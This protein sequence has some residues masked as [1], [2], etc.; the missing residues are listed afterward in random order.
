MPFPLTWSKLTR[1][2]AP[3]FGRRAE[4][5]G[6]QYLRSLGFLLLASPYRVVTGEIDIV[7]LDGDCLVFVEVKARR[8]DP[9]P[10]DA[11]NL[12]KRRR[13]ERAARHYRRRYPRRDLRYRFD[14]LAVVQPAGG[15]PEFRLIK[16]AFRESE[17]L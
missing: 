15:E 7:A 13:I 1:T 17:D 11:V 14:I 3:S 2:K 4:I 12:E 5:L 10:E 9:H 6:A 8:S 16:D